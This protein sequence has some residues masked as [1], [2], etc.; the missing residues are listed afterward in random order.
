MHLGHN[1]FQG[2]LLTPNMQSPDNSGNSSVSGRNRA[3]FGEKRRIRQSSPPAHFSLKHIFMRS[4]RIRPARVCERKR[5]SN[6]L[7]YIVTIIHV[8]FVR[9]SAD[10]FKIRRT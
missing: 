8:T 2:E 4:I 9:L 3:I 7:L 10:N 5:A 6:K 1:I